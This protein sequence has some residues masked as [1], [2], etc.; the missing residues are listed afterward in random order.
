MQTLRVDVVELPDDW[1]ANPLFDAIV[2]EMG[3]N[4]GLDVLLTEDAAGNLIDVLDRSDVI[5]VDA[6]LTWFPPSDLDSFARSLADR[7]GVSLTTYSRDNADLLNWMLRQERERANPLER[8]IQALSPSVPA[9]IEATVLST[10][11]HDT[12]EQRVVP[13]VAPVFQEPP[14]LLGLSD[15]PAED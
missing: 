6:P 7:M 2:A 13:N 10:V 11:V 5:P 3:L 15:D 1:D 14:S 9:I 4:P 12:G 8:M